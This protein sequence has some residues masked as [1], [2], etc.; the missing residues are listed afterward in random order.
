[1]KI[2]EIEKQ[3]D[4]FELNR[5]IFGFYKPW[6][7]NKIRLRFKKALQTAELRDMKIHSLR[8]GYASLL[9]NHGATVQELSAAFGDTLQV[10]LTTYAHM[11]ADTNRQISNRVDRII[12][13]VTDE[14][15]TEKNKDSTS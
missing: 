13:T 10:T 7:N 14:S 11:Y 1:M 3:K 4:G 2:Y 8:Y 12:A 5:F 9:A 6:S 15:D